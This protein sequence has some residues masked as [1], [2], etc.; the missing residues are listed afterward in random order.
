VVEVAVVVVAAVS[1]LDLP[2]ADTQA[3]RKAG[4]YQSQF[5]LWYHLYYYFGWRYQP[6]RP[7]QVRRKS[8]RRPQPLDSLSSLLCNR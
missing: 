6:Q 8:Q 2:S 1:V 3:R 5:P 4:R 7:R